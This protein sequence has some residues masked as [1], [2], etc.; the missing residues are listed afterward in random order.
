VV[1]AAVVPITVVKN[2]I[3]IVVLTLL[4]AHVDIRFLTGGF[5]HKSGGFLFY[6]PGLLLLGVVMLLLR[7][8]GLKDKKTLTR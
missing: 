3:R 1:V 7:R 6:I 8:V 2:A 5:L 4:A